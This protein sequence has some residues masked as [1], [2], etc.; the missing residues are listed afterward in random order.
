MHLQVR[1][2]AATLL[3]AVLAIGT[4]TVL[5]LGYLLAAFSIGVIMF[6]MT[7]KMI[8]RIADARL[9]RLRL[10]PGPRPSPPTRRTRISGWRR[11]PRAL[12]GGNL[13]CCCSWHSA[14]PAARRGRGNPNTL[15]APRF[16]D[17]TR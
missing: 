13:G 5:L 9:A 2:V 1:I 17:G 15:S 10:K 11:D 16:Q 6:I 8:K 12:P 3:F 7:R 4:G 14:R